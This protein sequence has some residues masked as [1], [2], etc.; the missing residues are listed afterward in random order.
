MTDITAAKPAIRWLPLFLLV[1]LG[2][3]WG[4]NPS[5]SKAL[6]IAGV[7]PF[8]VVFW[9]TFGAGTLLLLV[10]L[11]RRTS[12]RFRV[13]HLIYFAFMGVVGIDV[14]YVTLVFT[15]EKLS[16]G[17]VSVLILFSPMLTYAMA[18]VLRMEP[19]VAIRAVGI[20][21]G[22]AGAAVLVLPAGSL[23][24]RDLLP[25]ALL[26]F[27]TPL[28]YA[29][30]NIFAE[31][32]RP[33]DTDNVALAMGTMF[34]AAIGALSGAL[35]NN[36][37]YPAWQNFGHAETVL[38]LFALATSVAFLIFY[39]IIKMA[40]A[41]YLGQVGYLATLFGV[42]WGILFFAETPSAWLWLAALLVAAG[43][44][45]VNLGKPKPAT[46]ADDGA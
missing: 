32:A 11:L 24:S 40:G 26:A 5:F 29:A 3:L 15:V 44:A 39:A 34:A 35:I 19:M 1:V 18:L 12:L 27:I 41:V 30:A 20:V 37:F 42:S 14:S 6:A 2:A 4:G 9:Q 43:V 17:Y 36:S 21:V 13:K 22:L 25:L 7:S 8:S 31:I 46:R 45:L 38:A 23:P 28:G 33:P 16:A 10:C